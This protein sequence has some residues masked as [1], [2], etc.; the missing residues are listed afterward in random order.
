MRSVAAAAGCSTI[1]GVTR[2][3]LILYPRAALLNITTARRLKLEKW[4][5]LQFKG[6]LGF[7]FVSSSLTCKPVIPKLNSPMVSASSSLSPSCMKDFCLYHCSWIT[8]TALISTVKHTQAHTHPLPLI[9]SKQ[10]YF[11]LLNIFLLIST[12]LLVS[13]ASEKRIASLLA[14]RTFLSLH[15]CQPRGKSIVCKR[16]VS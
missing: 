2:V 7:S 11:L 1:N 15:Y 4:A 9:F 6:L 3:L 13:A 5:L 12:I 14:L 16:K 8:L 10:A